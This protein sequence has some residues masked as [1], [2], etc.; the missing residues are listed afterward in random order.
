MTRAKE[1]P[2]GHCPKY[3]DVKDHD[4][5]KSG[6]TFRTPVYSEDAIRSISVVAQPLAG[7]E[8][9]LATWFAIA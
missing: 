3:D 5:C 1:S 7:A 4:D 8:R 9:A 2:S 6:S